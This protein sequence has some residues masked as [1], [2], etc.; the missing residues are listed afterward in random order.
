MM[1][2]LAAGMVTFGESVA[3]SLIAKATVVLACA[4]AAGW[5][6]RHRRAA[7][8]H[9]IF[10]G[11]FAA[12][13]VLPAA[14]AAVPAVPVRLLTMPSIADAERAI[15]FN[16]TVEI[17]M[18]AAADSS[19]ARAASRTWPVLSPF[20]L[21]PTVWLAGV[22]CCLVPVALG[23]WQIRRVRRHGLPWREAQTTTNDL[24]R[25]AGYGRSIDVMVHEAIAGPM[26]C[27]V[28]RPAI[29]F[30]LDAR[31]WREADV[32]RAL[33]HELEH[34]RR[35]DWVTLCLAR[36][37]CAVYWFHP[38]V[39]IANRQLCVNAERACDDAV[40]RDSHAFGY[41]D[42]LVT[43]AERSLAQTRRPLL[44][45]ANRGDLSRRVHAVLS[46][47]QQRGPAG[48][49]ARLTV[50]IAAV[51]VV[52]L[53]A[54][55]RTVA[56]RLEQT[57]AGSRLTAGLQFEVASIKP[58]PFFDRIMSVRPLPGRLSAD[59]TLQVLMQHAYGVQ[60]FQLVG[61]PSWLTSDHYEIE[62][63]AD[64]SANRDQVF[65]MLQSL[66]EDR[67]QLKIHREI[68]ELPVFTLVSNR[69][70]FKLPAP[71][72]GACVDS[73]ADA[74]AE[75]VGAGRMAA[76]GEL[77]PAKGRCGSVIVSVAQVRG[78][79]IAMSEFVRTLSTLVGRSVLDR[80]GFTALFDVQLDFV[81]DETT[82]AM[83]SPPPGSG[84]SGISLAQALQ[85]Q[86]GLRLEPTKGPVE[87]LVVDHAERPSA[88]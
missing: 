1:R 6:A 14:T 11:A 27:G 56:S 87:V 45:M 7:V 3:L 72:D 48:V 36:A 68:K 2:L 59:A 50:T 24:A 73:P 19:E 31:T 53:L 78:G 70:G 77:P 32:R 86:L 41:A 58:S 63:K 5:L 12:L 88:N 18:L 13:A 28:V 47:R 65:R 20:T 71:R 66:L 15:P 52:A 51:A 60:P 42:Q 35:G 29:V 38:L 82:P 17:A 10:A 21:L 8:R 64:V 55:L 43:L 30:P 54:P 81:P 39:R 79:K 9:L 22:I 44:A 57:P 69:G 84:I 76:P 61:G 33:T 74:A 85:E 83:P 75:W 16:W 34:V 26:T 25:R 49:W 62:A 37:M 40:L 46:T 80:T 23:L 4:M 67:F